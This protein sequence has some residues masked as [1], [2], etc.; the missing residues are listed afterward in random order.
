[1]AAEYATQGA[2]ERVVTEE[3]GRCSLSSEARA[4]FIHEADPIGST[5]RR[6]DTEYLSPDSEARSLTTGRAS[7]STI[8]CTNPRTTFGGGC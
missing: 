8:R 2:S 7:P 3:K 6:V 4:R 5:L 1:M